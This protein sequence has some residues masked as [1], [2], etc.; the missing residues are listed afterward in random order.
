MAEGGPPA[1]VPLLLVMGLGGN[2]QMWGPL[3]AHL[4]KRGVATVAYDQPGLGGSTS[5][6][7]PRRM[8]GLATTAE[9]ILDVLGHQQVDVLG[10]SFGGGVAQQLAHQAPHRVRRLVLGA[11]SPGLVSL[12][13]VPRVWDALGGL[14]RP[15]GRTVY[16]TAARAWFG[17]A[18]RAELGYGARLAGPVPSLSGMAQQVFAASAWT[19]YFWLH[20]LRQPT[21]VL[22]G[23]SDPI[24]PLANSRLLAMRLADSRT[25]VVR[26]GGHLFLVER[27]VESAAV[28]AGFL[29]E[30]D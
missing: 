25:H 4:H 23:D 2:L 3:E 18:Q 16:E 27:A 5:Y 28:I 17:G 20:T 19:S 26:G 30:E 1:G 12:P 9:R 24:I 15:G 21:L 13:G 11:T 22:A 14:R 8:P 29:A 6:R 10:V 7:R